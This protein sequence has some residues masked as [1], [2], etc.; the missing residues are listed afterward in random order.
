MK[1]EHIETIARPTYALIRVYAGWCLNLDYV[2]AKIRE[3][4]ATRRPC[5]NTSEIEDTKV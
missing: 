1:V 3:D 2:C 5:S 4:A